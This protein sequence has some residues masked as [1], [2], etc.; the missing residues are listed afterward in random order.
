MA[1]SAFEGRRHNIPVAAARPAAKSAAAPQAAAARY[2]APAVVRSVIPH[3][4][5]P[6]LPEPAGADA[7]AV[8][9]Q[10]ERSQWWPECRLRAA[11]FEQLRTLL[12]HA[13]ATVPYYRETLRRAGYRP[14]ERLTPEIWAG[15]PI[16]GREDVRGAEAQ[17]RS[18]R[19]PPAH[20][21]IGR[22]ST[23]GSTGMSV[24]TYKTELLQEFYEVATLTEMVWHRR[25]ISRKAALIRNIRRGDVRQEG[26]TWFDSWGHPFSRLYKTGA[27]VF[28][29][30]FADPREQV[31]WLID[32]APDYIVSLPSNL[33]AVAHRAREMGVRLPPA[34]EVRSYGEA[35]D[36]DFAQLCRDVWGAAHTS[37]YSTEEL[38]VVAVQ[39]PQRPHFHV[40][41][42]L[43]LAEV[44]KEDGRPCGPGE[45]GTV[46]ITP[47]HNFVMP[48]IRYRIGDLAEVGAPCAC[49]RGLPVW[50]R[51]L[52]RTRNLLAMANGGWR[53]FGSVGGALSHVRVIVQHQIVQRTRTDI[54]LNLVT[55]RPLTPDEEQDVF[56]SLAKR[57]G[58]GYRYRVVYVDSIPRNRE[59]KYEDFRSDL[60]PP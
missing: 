7:L 57:L 15:L 39:C 48:L 34:I 29:D 37:L 41:S 8:L 55:R 21:G 20:G 26:A 5:W 46:I 60:T 58:E 27:L 19:L 35:F 31:E 18:I 3:M 51:I 4:V 52:G 56:K 12:D 25:D 13:A 9:F 49:G 16:L 17:L 42:E 53:H 40:R 23:S 43:V 44:L 1:R 22:K 6:A 2:V 33:R 11:Q 28:C 50:T 47:L 45:V 59:G 38:G 30:V 32:E 10:M 36:D 54:D 14:G 24:V